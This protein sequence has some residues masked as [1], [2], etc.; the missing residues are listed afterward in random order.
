MKSQDLGA[1]N[2]R[3]RISKQTSDKLKY[4]K[5]LILEFA[6]KLSLKTKQIWSA[7]RKET[8]RKFVFLRRVS[9]RKFVFL[10]GS[11]VGTEF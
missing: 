10:D 4:Q 8:R 9:L 1:V 11:N 6:I 7:F 5:I 2:L 3:K